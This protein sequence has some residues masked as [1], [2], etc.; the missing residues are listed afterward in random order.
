VP[1]SDSFKRIE[2]GLP[3]VWVIQPR[4]VSDARGFFLESYNQSQFAALGIADRFVQDN[5]SRSTR[6]VL[7]GLHYQLKHPQAKLCR[8]IEGTVFDVA[9]DVRV[10]SSSFGKWTGVELSAQNRNQIY[11]PKGFAHGFVVLSEAAQILYKCSDYYDPADEAGI[12]WNDPGLNIAWGI[13]EPILSE[14]DKQFKRL[15]Q[16]PS[17]RLPRN[18]PE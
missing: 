11:I 10:G 8:V 2:T 4:I 14:R 18:H 16:I 7:R 5:Q 13:A 12:I 1:D 6:G 9:V 17:E 3:G 15:D